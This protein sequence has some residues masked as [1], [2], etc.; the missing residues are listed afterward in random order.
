MNDQPEQKGIHLA[1]GRDNNGNIA[2]GSNITQNNQINPEPVR[3]NGHVLP[4]AVSPAD[5]GQEPQQH[6]FKVLSDYFNKGE[7]RDL[8]FELGIDYDD[9]DGDT[10]RDKARELV[11]FARRHGRLDELEQAVL[12]ARPKAFIAA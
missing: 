3:N 6:L 12:R 9:L 4:F 1:I 2:I 10:R 11:A 5:L 7:L 8:C